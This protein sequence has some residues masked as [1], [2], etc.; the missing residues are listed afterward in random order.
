MAEA[1]TIWV[2]FD[3]DDLVFPANVERGELIIDSAFAS[4]SGKTLTVEFVKADNS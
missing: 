2:D 3:L 4:N 1:T